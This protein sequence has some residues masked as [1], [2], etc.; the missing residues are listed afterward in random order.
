M[1]EVTLRYYLSD[2]LTTAVVGE[3]A[4]GLPAMIASRLHVE[5]EEEAHLTAANIEVFTLE[6]NRSLDV[7][8]FPMDFAVR[9]EAM[10]FE[11]RAAKVQKVSDDLKKELQIRYPE[12]RFNVWIPLVVA[13]GYSETG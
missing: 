12:L 5:E 2:R 1:P 3:I 6:G 8:P 9:I 4:Q 7:L 11:Q 10:H 13:A